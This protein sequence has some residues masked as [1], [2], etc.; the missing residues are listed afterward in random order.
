MPKITIKIEKDYLND[1]LVTV[2]DV[3]ESVIDELTSSILSI[4]ANASVY[5]QVP[6]VE[7]EGA[8]NE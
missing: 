8:I 7:V 1:F 3:D 5:Q 6:P 4:L 2:N